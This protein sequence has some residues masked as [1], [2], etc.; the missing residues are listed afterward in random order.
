M[1][2]IHASPGR[3]EELCTSIIG[4]VMQSGWAWKLS[5]RVK[6]SFVHSLNPTLVFFVCHNLFE[7]ESPSDA[8]LACW[9]LVSYT[10][11][12]RKIH[13]RIWDAKVGELW[14]VLTT[15][16]H[17]LCTNSGLCDPVHDLMSAHNSSACRWV[18]CTKSKSVRLRTQLPAG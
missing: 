14:T 13:T 5:V 12:R 17:C 4:T 1:L 18:Q 11:Y 15:C 2:R 3:P 6:C 7:H 8:L 10:V 9:H 16:P